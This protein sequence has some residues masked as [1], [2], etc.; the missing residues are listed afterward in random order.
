MLLTNSIEGLETPFSARYSAA[1]V[2]LFFGSDAPSDFADSITNRTG[3][4]G[5]SVVF[6]AA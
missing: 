6:G 5:L 2:R 4:Y 3:S 1:A